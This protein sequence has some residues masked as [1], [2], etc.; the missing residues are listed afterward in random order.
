M[1]TTLR[2]ASL[3][4]LATLVAPP[5]LAF[6]VC[7]T[8]EMKQ[9]FVPRLKNFLSP[10]SRQDQCFDGYGCVPEFEKSEE[11]GR[12]LGK[13][14]TYSDTPEDVDVH[15]HAFGCHRHRYRPKIVSYNVAEKE[16]VSKAFP[17]EANKTTAVIIHGFNDKYDEMDWNGVS[18]KV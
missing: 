9:N 16:L 18:F 10:S 5:T 11:L 12:Y 13:V 14:F 4:F 3:I 1:Y 2:L 8:P 17:F 15:F 7:F 6:S